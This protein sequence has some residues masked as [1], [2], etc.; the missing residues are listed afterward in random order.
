MFDEF[1]ASLLVKS[2]NFFKKKL[3]NGVPR[4]LVTRVPFYMNI[5]EIKT[6]RKIIFLLN[7]DKESLWLTHKE[8]LFRFAL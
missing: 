2:I 7:P 3:L 8:I 6:W 1:N 4:N 5:L